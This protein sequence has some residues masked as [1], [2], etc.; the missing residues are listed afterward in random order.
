MRSMLF[1]P[2]ELGEY[3]ERGDPPLAEWP[4][5]IRMRQDVMAACG[6]KRDWFRFGHRY[7]AYLRYWN[8]WADARA[9]R[10]DMS[11][12]FDWDQILI[13]GEYGAGKTTLGI[14]AA[15]ADFRPW[16]LHL[17]QCRLPCWVAAGL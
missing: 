7:E 9:R 13:I 8:E 16:P 6:D 15:L 3:A 1:D 2:P 5:T 17:L 14:K 11:S 12:G 4:G 10:R